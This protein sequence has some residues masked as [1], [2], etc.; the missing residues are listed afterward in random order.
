VFDTVYTGTRVR[1]D[2]YDA[3]SRGCNTSVSVTVTVSTYE[4]QICYA[5]AAILRVS[6]GPEAHILAVGVHMR[7]DPPRL[8][9]VLLYMACNPVSVLPSVAVHTRIGVCRSLNLDQST[10]R[11]NPLTYTP[12]RH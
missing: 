1:T 8:T 9:A 12:I 3:L 6:W 2:S 10:P 7:T 5:V 11:Y 4:S